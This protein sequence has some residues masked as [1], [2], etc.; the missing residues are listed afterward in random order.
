MSPSKQPS[1]DRT[2]DS[3]VIGHFPSRSVSNLTFF[4]GKKMV[5]NLVRM[6]KLAVFKFRIFFP[7]EDD[8]PYGHNI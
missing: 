4:S 2:K 6:V 1:S 5:Y 3:T 7:I 8:I